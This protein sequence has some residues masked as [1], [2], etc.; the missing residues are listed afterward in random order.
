MKRLARILALSLAHL[1]LIALIGFLLLAN[2]LPAIY[3]SD[4]F[5][6]MFPAQ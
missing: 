2:W 4:W 1:I 5:R 6:A 3:A